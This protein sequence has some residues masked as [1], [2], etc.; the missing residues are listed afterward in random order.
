MSV[1]LQPDS[2]GVSI[3]TVTTG[4]RC[5]YDSIDH[6]QMIRSLKNKSWQLISHLKSSS[7]VHIS[8]FMSGFRPACFAIVSTTVS[9]GLPSPTLSHFPGFL[10]Q[11]VFIAKVLRRLFV[12]NFS[13]SPCHAVWSARHHHV[14]CLS[15]W[16]PSVSVTKCIVATT[17][18]VQQ[19]CRN[20]VNSR[21]HDFTTFNPLNRHH[22]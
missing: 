7:R 4:G 6:C 1:T 19:K 15:V 13:R 12:N 20:N 14:V 16:R 21:E 17:Y 8:M 22:L 2:P 18:P 3:L 11:Y 9:T 10:C 5:V